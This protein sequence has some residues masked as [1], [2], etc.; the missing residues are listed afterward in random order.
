VSLFTEFMEM[1][2]GD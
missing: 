2:T 1:M